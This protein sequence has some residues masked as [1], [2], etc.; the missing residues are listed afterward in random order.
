MPH[1]SHPELLYRIALTMVVSHIRGP[2]LNK[3]FYG[4]FWKSDISVEVLITLIVP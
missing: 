1:S 2:L 4:Y 3:L